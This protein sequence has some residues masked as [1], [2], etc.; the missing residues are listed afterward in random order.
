MRKIAIIIIFLSIFI[1][2]CTLPQEFEPTSVYLV[3]DSGLYGKGEGAIYK[4]DIAYTKN[5]FDYILIQYHNIANSIRGLTVR[6]GLY[7]MP[8]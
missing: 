8:K 1:F 3:W 6:V 7:A 2:S 4:Q 5:E